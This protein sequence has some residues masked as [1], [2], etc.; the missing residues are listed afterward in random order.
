MS[1]KK[2]GCMGWMMILLFFPLILGLAMLA[3]SLVVIAGII[4]GMVYCYK[5]GKFDTI[6]VKIN[7]LIG[8]LYN[9][10]LKKELS[11]PV[12]SQKVSQLY[13]LY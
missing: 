13:Q 7:E 4:Y 8:K 9:K 11:K 5:N 12:L 3:L 6:T 2:L 10:V 1:K